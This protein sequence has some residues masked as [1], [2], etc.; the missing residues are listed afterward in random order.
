MSREEA[1][2]RIRGRYI[3]TLQLLPSGELEAGM[4]LVEATFP[5]EVTT[6]LDWAVVVAER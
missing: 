6:R 3:S 2:E 5:H 4:A 1:V